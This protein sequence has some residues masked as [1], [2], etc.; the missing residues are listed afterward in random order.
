MIIHSISC[1]LS[2]RKMIHTKCH[3]ILSLKNNTHNKSFFGND[4]WIFYYQSHNQFI[5]T[6]AEDTL[7]LFFFQGKKGLKF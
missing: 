3:V 7:S 6:A 2:A 1:E 4:I 5:M